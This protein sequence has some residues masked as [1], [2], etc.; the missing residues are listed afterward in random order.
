MM[1]VPC[2]DAS[3]RLAWEALNV[4]CDPRLFPTIDLLKMAPP[5]ELKVAPN[6]ITGTLSASTLTQRLKMTRLSTNLAEIEY[7]AATILSIQSS[8]YH[9][10]SPP[11]MYL[12]TGG[13]RQRRWPS[14]SLL[15]R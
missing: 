11:Q 6:K 13:Y 4:S 5:P 10:D 14:S 8:F 7:A 12:N 9:I 2:E 1:Q 15:F 3:V